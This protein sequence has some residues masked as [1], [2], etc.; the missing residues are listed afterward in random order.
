MLP[1]APTPVRPLDQEGETRQEDV[2]LP[3]APTPVR[4][5]EEDAA[6]HNDD[7]V[8]YISLSLIERSYA[9]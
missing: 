5:L 2:V 4:P 3:R 9:L 6:S 7:D 8:S 1:R